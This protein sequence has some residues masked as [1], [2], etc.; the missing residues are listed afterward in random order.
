MKR[1]ATSSTTDDALEPKKRKLTYSTYEKWRSNFDRECKTVMWLACKTEMAG[2]KRWVKRLNC[3]L[4]KKYKEWISGRRN[5][6]ERWISGAG[7]LPTSNIKDHA[8]SDQ[9]QHV[10]SLLQREKAAAR[11]D[12]ASSFAPI[13]AVLNTLSG[14]ERETLS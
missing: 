3:T 4:C 6:S 7:S 14:E 1:A 12:S 13:A 9:H 2:G 11:G 10:I 5:Y 8:H